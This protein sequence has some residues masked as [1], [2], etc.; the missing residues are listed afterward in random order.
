MDKRDD[1]AMLAQSLGKATG[2]N[3]VSYHGGMKAAE[4]T[5]A[6]RAWTEGDAQVAVATVAFGMGVDLAHVRYVVHWT[7]AKSIESFYQESGR[8]GRDGLPAY[9]LLY[10]SRDDARLFDFLARQK[11]PRNKDDKSAE[12]S[13]TRGSRPRCGAS[14][15]R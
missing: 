12:K 11:K 7:L 4:R 9:S 14:M 6:Q 8:G 1:T 3:V 5:E 15:R 2:L 13:T 10:Y